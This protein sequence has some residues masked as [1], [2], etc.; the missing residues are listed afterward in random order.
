M[1]L[2]KKNLG[3]FAV[4]LTTIVLSVVLGLLVSKIRNEAREYEKSVDS[5]RSDL[6]KV[7]L[8]PYNL[9]FENVKQMQDNAKKAKEEYDTLV[10]TLA[11]RYDVKPIPDDMTP[12]DVKVYV[13]NQSLAMHQ[14]LRGS[15][16][17]VTSSLTNFGFD[18]F[19]GAQVFPDKEQIRAIRRHIEITREIVNTVAQ[20]R[21]PVLD[22]LQRLPSDLKLNQLEHYRYC[23]YRLSLRG[24]IDQI[25]T[26]LRAISDSKR[27]F[28]LVRLLRVNATGDLSTQLT[29]ANASSAGIPAGG[30]E[31]GGTP[32]AAVAAAAAA[33]S[34]I[35]HDD[36]VVF[37]QLT[38]LRAE[39]DLDYIEFRQPGAEK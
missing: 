24:D 7:K 16:C 29:P 8:F 11:V 28:F 34:T 20:S 12:I 2:I 27:M 37:R 15:A 18:S 19:L 22:S 38:E 17:T 35:K 36:R 21:I 3:L 39:I 9:T 4:L 30:G 10:A 6:D 25:Q 5:I 23:T 13:Q 31:A 33:A 26:F 14:R 32:S 1:D